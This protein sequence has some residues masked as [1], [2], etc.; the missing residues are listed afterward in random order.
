VVPGALL[1]K[2]QFMEGGLSRSLGNSRWEAFLN[3][4]RGGRPHSPQGIM[5]VFTGKKG[6]RNGGENSRHTQV[7]T[8]KNSYEQQP[9]EMMTSL[10]PYRWG[11]DKHLKRRKVER[12]TNNDYVGGF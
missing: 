12:E 9:E 6:I 10:G 2:M 8:G 1:G 3:R 5:E 7:H 11:Y 4:R